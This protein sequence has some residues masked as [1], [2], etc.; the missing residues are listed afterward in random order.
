MRYQSILFVLFIFVLFTGCSKK[1][2]KFPGFSITDS[3]IHYKLVSLGDGASKAAVTDFITVNISYRTINDS[4]FFQGL[5]KFQ[6]TS[7]RFE[8]SIDEC[9]MML[10]LGDSATFYI[11]AD[12]F[13]TRTLEASLPR[14]IKSGDFMRIDIKM[15]DIQNEKVYEQEK[16]AFLHWIDDFGDYEKVILKQY[17]EGKKL[18]ISPTSSGLFYIPVVQSQGKNVAIGDTI[19]VHY[20]GR[21]FNGKYFDST[22]KR[23]EAFQFVYGQKWQVIEGL[24]EA[25]GMMKEGEKALF[26]IPSRLAFGEQGSSTG[27]IPPFTSVVFEVELLEVKKGKG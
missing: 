11:P 2:S 13:F 19:T 25:I 24:E 8:G 26:I 21:F 5:R 15:I 9:F 1:S 7:P 16:E 12:T 23:N 18:S 20:E 14:F 3:G 6:L 27:I 17:M 4:L 10:T 22:K